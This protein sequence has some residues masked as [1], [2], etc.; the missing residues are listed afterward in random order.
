MCRRECA[1]WIV[2]LVQLFAMY[3]LIIHFIDDVTFA[4]P[5]TA[6]SLN[7]AV[8][9]IVMMMISHVIIVIFKLSAQRKKHFPTPAYLATSLSGHALAFVVAIGLSYYLYTGSGSTLF[10]FCIVGLF[11]HLAGEYVSIVYQ[12]PH[13]PR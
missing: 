13:N 4:T 3:Y 1:I 10:T 12:P 2:R 7:T 8:L 11:M 5:L 6:V 9:V